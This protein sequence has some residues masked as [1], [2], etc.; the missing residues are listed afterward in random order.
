MNL[1][2]NRLASLKGFTVIEAIVSLAVLGIGTVAVVSLVSNYNTQL[3][4]TEIKSGFEGANSQ[5]L[6]AISGMLTS[7]GKPMR[8]GLCSFMKT[9]ASTGGRGF[10]Y[11]ELPLQDP[12]S[13]SWIKAFPADKWTAYDCVAPSD[14]SFPKFSSIANAWQKCFKPK[15]L[16]VAPPFGLPAG[17]LKNNPIFRA[18]VTPVRVRVEGKVDPK[19]Q[20]PLEGDAYKGYQ[21]LTLPQLAANKLDARDTALIVAAEVSY[22]STSA[23]GT[24]AETISRSAQQQF[25]MLWFG[26]YQCNGD[27]SNNANLILRPSA[28]GSGQDTNSLFSASQNADATVITGNNKFNIYTEGQV[29][30]ERGV[31]RL[32][33]DYLAAAACIE[34]PVFHCKFKQRTKSDWSEASLAATLAVKYNANNPVTFSS[35][36]TATPNLSLQT[37]TN[38]GSLDPIPLDGTAF[39]V[40][41]INIPRTIAGKTYSTYDFGPSTVRLE[42]ATPDPGQACNQVCSPAKNY[43]N[44]PNPYVL[45]YGFESGGETYPVKDTTSKVGCVCCYGKQCGVIGTKLQ[46]WCGAQPDEALDS[47]LPECASDSENPGTRAGLVELKSISTASGSLRA[48]SFSSQS[49]CLSAT[50]DSDTL[51]VRQESV[52]SPSDKKP[53]LCFSQGRFV[54]TKKLYARS[55]AA[56]G[57]YDMSWE[58]VPVSEID[59]RMLAQLGNKQDLWSFYKKSYMPPV[60]NG[61]YVF[62]NA[63]MA[64]LFVAPQEDLQI[65]SV[66]GLKSRDRFWI[67]YRSNEK[68]EL[69]ALPP[70]M[71]P[72]I[73][74]NLSFFDAAGQLTFINDNNIYDILPFS[75]GAVRASNEGP[76]I[77]HHGRRSFGS[78]VIDPVQ[79]SGNAI[80]ALCWNPKTSKFERSTGKTSDYAKALGLC[81][82]DK[83]LFTAPLRPLQWVASLLVAMPNA[84]TLPFP[85][86]QG[87]VT[88]ADATL[89]TSLVRKGGQYVHPLPVMNPNE[90]IVDE[91]LNVRPF[92]AKDQTP[93]PQYQLMRVGGKISLISGSV[94]Q[95]DAGTVWVESEDDELDLFKQILNVSTSGHLAIQYKDCA[96]PVPGACGSANGVSVATAPSTNLCSEGTPSSVN[97]FGPWDWKCQGSPNTTAVS[98][99]APKTITPAPP[100][101][102]LTPVPTPPI[103]AAPPPTPLIPVTT[104]PPAACNW[105]GWKV[106]YSVPKS[107]GY[108]FTKAPPQAAFPKGAVATCCKNS[109]V[110]K[111]FDVTDYVGAVGFFPWCPQYTGFPGQCP[112]GKSYIDGALTT[113]YTDFM[114]PKCRGSNLY[115]YSACLPPCP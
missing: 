4:N 109:A 43:N 84:S 30:Q 82:A 61:R 50:I 80:S 36:L 9:N 38:D 20:K 29:I 100:P 81:L 115:R 96:K 93:E 77:L 88:L 95:Q 90:C 49:D 58:S 34:K 22:D 35:V 53:V 99:S 25:S 64:G 45:S 14:S 11:S 17:V 65:K 60:V 72:N 15:D 2:K 54:L 44:L 23:A 56:Q 41:T 73:S 28:I 87:N 62:R 52:C 57:C 107:N 111:T 12:F 71:A 86:F 97:G 31:T 74:A 5:A 92:S 113:W 37:K 98:C 85:V 104:P 89:W 26:E 83:K 67:A 70:E 76:F 91:Q 13:S 63:V 18:I 46:S 32:G 39:K 108:N 7:T 102:P 103:P 79:N 110:V 55:D 94:R 114:G 101:V 40:G 21:A 51:S 3:R 66:I 24:S 59:E 1:T 78:Q 6:A 112:T 19:T 8:Q 16:E 68:K 105:D 33:S 106:D 10:I 47:R 42:S 48:D 69:V 75:R 27:K